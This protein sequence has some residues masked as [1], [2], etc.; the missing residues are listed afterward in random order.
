M[1]SWRRGGSV[2]AP[3]PDVR[4]PRP[5][6]ARWGTGGGSWTYAA[7]RRSVKDVGG[8]VGEYGI[9][10]IGEAQDVDRE[11]RSLA[12]WLRDDDAIRTSALVKLTQAPPRPGEMGGAFD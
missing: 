5:F 7:I 2:Q 11:S 10:V 9:R 4:R 6:C 8:A 12:R 1:A 3:L